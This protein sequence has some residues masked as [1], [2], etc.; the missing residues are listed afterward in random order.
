MSAHACMGVDGEFRML[1]GPCF[2]ERIDE[3][4]TECRD[5]NSNQVELTVSIMLRGNP[6]IIEAA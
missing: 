4:Y 6:I 1:V 2:Q 5:A 3:M